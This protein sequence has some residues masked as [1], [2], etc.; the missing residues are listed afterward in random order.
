M[1]NAW[2]L[3]SLTVVALSSASCRHQIPL[4]GATPNAVSLQE[5]YCWWAVVRSPLPPDSVVA[6]FARAFVEVGLHDERRASV[7]DTAWVAA[8]PSPLPGGTLAMSRVVAFRAGDSTHFRHFIG[9]AAR[10]ANDSES[11][12]P[13]TG[14]CRD[15]ARAA[16][17]GAVAPRDPTGG[18]SRSVWSRGAPGRP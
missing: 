16:A 5:E 7:G 6:R 14:L 13:L 11:P 18:E 10:A 3:A 1:A 12:S 9:I 4:A 17:V 15:I 8:G 2:R